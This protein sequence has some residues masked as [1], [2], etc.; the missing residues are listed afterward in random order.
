[1]SGGNKNSEK[2]GFLQRLRR[3]FRLKIS[4]KI[5]AYF[6]YIALVPLASVSYVLVSQASEQLLNDA[7]AKQQAVAND[8][9]RRVDNYLA[10]DMNQLALTARL[11]STQSFSTTQMDNTFKSLFSQNASLQSV[12]L[13]TPNGSQ[14]TYY[15]KG[16]DVTIENSSVDLVTSKAL[17]F[18]A[19]KSYLL[20][21]G[22]DEQNIPQV[23][24]GI[25]ILKKYG[26]P[27]SG[28]FALPSGTKD[29]LLGA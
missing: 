21:V 15:Q 6:L 10:N 12:T 16:S 1:M 17:D 22:R 7:S 5:L 20:S 14:R 26:P 28:L 3:I 25:P 18:L 23:N 9:S 24:I 11:Y 27:D 4:A 29:N 13:Q 8:L 19:G 2:T